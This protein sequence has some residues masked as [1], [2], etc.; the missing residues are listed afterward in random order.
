MAK[1]ISIGNM[2]S[3]IREAL[4]EYKEVTDEVVKNAVDSV[5][6]EAKTIAK[7]GSPERYG[8][9]KQGWAVK[10]T[11]DRSSQVTASF[12][13]SRSNQRKTECSGVR[14]GTGGRRF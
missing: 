3:A 2:G 8:G 10:K 11:V 1:K 13:G 14:T 5:S 4:E 6:K 12:T 9:Y 7:T